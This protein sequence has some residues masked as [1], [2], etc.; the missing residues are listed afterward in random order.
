MNF[1]LEPLPYSYDALSPFMSKETLCFHHDKHHLTYVNNLNALIENTKFSDMPLEDIIKETY[2]KSEYQAIFNNASQHLNHIEFWKSLK[3]N[4]EPTK[5]I[6]SIISDHFDSMECFKDKIITEGTKVF[7]SGWVWLCKT[8]DQKLEIIGTSN[9][10]NP[11]ALGK[12]I[13]LGCDVW[14]HSY[15]LDYKNARAQ[16][17]NTWFDKIINWD[18]VEEKLI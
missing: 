1:T 4:V 14:E 10:I 2:N 11:V 9:A 7:G 8:K 6:I 3:A 15:Y 16:Y 5:K 18:Y 13:I 17:L 12:E